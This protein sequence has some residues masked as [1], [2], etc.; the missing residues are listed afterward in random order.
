MSET[1]G[2][3]LG[4]LYFL[5]GAEN[6]PSSVELVLTIWAIYLL[7]SRSPPFRTEGILAVGYGHYDPNADP[8]AAAN[9]VGGDYW[10]IKNS[11]GEGWGLDGCE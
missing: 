7:H 8:D 2:G 9:S 1:A 4:S 5:V 6:V 11:W 10:L 3:I